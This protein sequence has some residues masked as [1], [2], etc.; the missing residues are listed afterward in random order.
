M[1]TPIKRVKDL[2]DQDA[3]NQRT[4]AAAIA[5]PTF[6][7]PRFQSM[8]EGKTGTPQSDIRLAGLAVKEPK[9]YSTGQTPMLERTLPDGNRELS[10]G[11]NT[12][13]TNLSESDLNIK[14]NVDALNAKVAS[15]RPEDITP[16]QQA[17]IQGIREQAGYTRGGVNTG[18]IRAPQTNADILAKRQPGQAVRYTGK[19]GLTAEFAPSASNQEI[20][21]FT[22]STRTEVA[23]TNA[24]PPVESSRGAQFAVALPEPPSPPVMLPFEPATN[25]R[26]MAVYDAEMQAYNNAVNAS[27]TQR[28]QDIRAKADTAAQADADAQTRIKWAEL[29]QKGATAKAA[30]GLTTAQTDDANF[31][32]KIAREALDPRTP[33]ERVA[34]ILVARQALEGRASQET[35]FRKYDPGTP[36][37]GGQGGTME[38]VVEQQ[39]DGTYVKRPVAPQSAEDPYEYQIGEDGKKY[40]RLKQGAK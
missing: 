4:T 3:K 22:D 13:Q 34:Q 28:G 2:D 1:A 36:A 8:L 30:Q 27:V 23:R 25:R 16:E 20:Q 7:D 38:G 29:D 32:A 9:A 31:N 6:S 12:L 33:P 11:G 35:P 21:A 24:R 39:P 26:K 40:R 37:I 18:Q 17:Q 14:R 10:I 15:M 19:N 5:T